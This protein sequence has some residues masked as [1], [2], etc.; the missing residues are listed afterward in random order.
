M[1]Y[2]FNVSLEHVNELRY[3][4]LEES[5]K[6]SCINNQKNKISGNQMDN[7][8]NILEKNTSAL[9][10]KR[11]SRKNHKKYKHLQTMKF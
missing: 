7:F 2:F 3:E 5:S 9:N 8:G 6:T 1:Q 10:T 4:F 11:P